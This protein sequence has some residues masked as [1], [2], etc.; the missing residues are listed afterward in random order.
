MYDKI[1]I[2]VG[3]DGSVQSK[4]ALQ[5]AITI[6]KRFSGFLKVITVSEKTSEK[7]EIILN[8]AQKELNKDH[9]RYEIQHIIGNSPSKAIEIIAKQENFDLIVVG[10]R[11]LGNKI[12]MLLGSVSKNIVG[13]AYC[14]VLVV[15]NK[16]I[17]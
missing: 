14:N 5:E 9:V 17:K 11:G 16:K 15:K 13:N 2:L 8:D 3:V 10:S 1:R 12:S 6:A 4:R 7:T